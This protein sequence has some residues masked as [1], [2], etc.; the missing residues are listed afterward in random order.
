MTI[1][2]CWSFRNG[3]AVVE[4]DGFSGNGNGSTSTGVRK[5]GR[6]QIRPPRGFSSNITILVG[7]AGNITIVNYFQGILTFRTPIQTWVVPTNINGCARI[8]VTGLIVPKVNLGY[9]I[10]N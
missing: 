6:T 3:L 2:L 9:L 8:V 4:A 10:S 1:H 5:S 7:R